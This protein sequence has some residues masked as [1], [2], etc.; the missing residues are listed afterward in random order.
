M[1]LIK[2]NVNLSTLIIFFDGYII[3]N[4]DLNI[5]VILI[6]KCLLKYYRKLKFNVFMFS[7]VIYVIRMINVKL[8]YYYSF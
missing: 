5:F 6:L 8:L 1:T 7:Y 3:F 2:N 4:V